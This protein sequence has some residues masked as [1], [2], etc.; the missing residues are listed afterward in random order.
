MVPL[1][2][3][4]PG[5]TTTGGEAVSDDEKDDKDGANDNENSDAGYVP[6]TPSPAGTRRQRTG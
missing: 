1:T 3:Q 4:P 5:A 2:P 6:S